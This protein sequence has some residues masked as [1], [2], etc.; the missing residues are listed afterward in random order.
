MC[1]RHSSFRAPQGPSLSLDGAGKCV[2]QALQASSRPSWPWHTVRG[3]EPEPEPAEETGWA[4]RRP[5][6][7]PLR[8]RGWGVGSGLRQAAVG[9]G[10][11]PRDTQSSFLPGA[12][13]PGCG[14]S[15]QV[16]FAWGGRARDGRARD[17]WSH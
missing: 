10:S 5:G 1:P 13:Q 9:R 17:G 15:R 12:S 14:P 4:C 16:G 8:R 2:S 11:D 6:R 7:G 3:E